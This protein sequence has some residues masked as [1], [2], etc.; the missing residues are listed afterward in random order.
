MKGISA[1]IA[2]ILMLMITIALAGT[3]YMYIRGIFTG[4]VAK[5][6]SIIDATC[7]AGSAYRITVKNLDSSLSI[8]ANTELT[9]MVDNKPVTTVSWNP[10]TIPAGGISMATVTN[11]AGGTAGTAHT[12]KVIGPS[13]SDEEPA[14]C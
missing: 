6:I 9:V 14:Y 3:A 5:A 4:S 7:E 8:T 1:V 2:T 12:I 11:P 13:N 10:T